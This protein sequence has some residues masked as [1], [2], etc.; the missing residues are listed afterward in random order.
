MKSFWVSP[1]ND[2]AE[3]YVHIIVGGGKVGYYL[4]KTLLQDEHEI[5][6]YR[7]RQAQRG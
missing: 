3:P 7:E 2:K 1:K 4:A 6:D 5:F